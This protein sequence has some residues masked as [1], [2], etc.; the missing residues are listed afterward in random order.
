M[1]TKQSNQAVAAA[2]PAPSAPTPTATYYQELA[3]GILSA[4]NDLE[5]KIPQFESAHESTK[6]FV[7]SYVGVPLKFLGTA[8]AAVEQ[9]PELQSLQRLDVT[10]AHDTLQFI[11]AFA[12]VLDRVNAF[13]RGIAFTMSA[14]RASLGADALQIYDITKGLS[15]DPGSAAIAL[16]VENMKRAL[17]RKGHPKKTSTAAA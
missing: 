15:R 1:S 2:G 14:R 9:T 3:E 17:G 7:R 4:I 10:K 11:D 16:H 12:Q 5:A 8:V 6:S 13:A